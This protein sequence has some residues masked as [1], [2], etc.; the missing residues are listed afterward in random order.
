MN[1]APRLLVADLDG[2]LLHDAPTFEE[3]F[4]TQRTIDTIERL[5][6]A[7][8]RFAVSTARPVSTGYR[9]AER[10][11]VDAVVYLN[12]ALIDFAP[13]ES[14]YD[15]LVSG[16]AQAQ[17]GHL[18]RVGFSSRR[19]CE[20]CLFLLEELPGLEV[21]IV[22][23]DVRYTNFDVSEHWKTQVWRYTDFKD[24]PEGTAD[25]IICFPKPDQWA[26][27]RELVPPDFAMGVSEG[28]MAMLMNPL[29]DK[30]HS[31]ETLCTRMEIPLAQTASFGDDLIDIPMLETSGLGVAVANAN[32]KVLAT[33]D[34]VC[35]ANNE[36][37][38][39]QW[40][41]RHLLH[42]TD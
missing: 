1:G 5:H 24:V 11:P 29:A 8:F 19:A 4:I 33:A 28:T 39:A 6:D 13:G 22:M 15:L 12:G 18:M 40:I 20:V 27:L 21:G 23:D 10:L 3:R 31:L 34:E 36:D 38:V 42:A 41:E 30:R 32:P 26:R 14:S 2:T 16:A 17:W 9:F 35:P 37:G 7:G 25:K